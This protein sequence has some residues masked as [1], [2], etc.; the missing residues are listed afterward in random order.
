MISDDVG[1]RDQSIV[2]SHLGEPDLPPLLSGRRSVGGQS[3]LDA[4]RDGAAR[5]ALGAGDLIWNDDPAV[6][7][8][9]IVLEPDI[10]LKAAAQVLPMAMVAVGDCLGALAP[11]QVGVMFRWPNHILVNGA[12]AGSVRLVASGDEAAHVPDWLVIGIELR[13]HHPAEGREPGYDRDRTALA[14]EGCEELS[15]LQIIESCARHFLTWLNT[16]QDDGFQPV[17][18]NWLSRADGCDD[19]IEIEGVDGAVLVTGMDE[20]GNLLIKSGSGEIASLALLDAVVTTGR[21]A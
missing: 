4:A 2:E 7:D 5:A 3:A 14:E 1:D 11:P 13:L 20:D 6:V 15:S 8:I 16:W 19:A 12:L 9:A 21:T 10:P 18:E 17:H